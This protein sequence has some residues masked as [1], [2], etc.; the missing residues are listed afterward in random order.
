MKFQEIIN[1]TESILLAAQM[2]SLPQFQKCINSSSSQKIYSVTAKISENVNNFYE[3][4]LKTE[5]AFVFNMEFGPSPYTK[6]KQAQQKL[7][8]AV[9]KYK[10]N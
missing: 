10:L 5:L 6:Q 2:Q 4:N 7:R 8:N 3:R 1:K 9:L